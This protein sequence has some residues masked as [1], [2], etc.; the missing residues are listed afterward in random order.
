[1]KFK[2]G[3]LWYIEI[4]LWIFDKF[5]LLNEFNIK[6]LCMFGAWMNVLASSIYSYQS[7]KFTRLE[8]LR[9]KLEFE[10]V[11]NA[12][13]TW[14]KFRSNYMSTSNLQS[15]KLI[16]VVM[17]IMIRILH[18]KCHLVT[19]IF[20]KFTHYYQVCMSI[21]MPF[22]CANSFFLREKNSCKLCK[23]NICMLMDSQT[24]VHGPNVVMQFQITCLMYVDVTPT[25]TITFIVAASSLLYIDLLINLLPSSNT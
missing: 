11:S 25:T 7:S 17:R 21:V 22:K 18:W 16:D 13:W 9:R 12:Q 1:M 10:Y 23:H 14:L 6:I 19:F 15:T 5:W 3:V 4:M 2:E 24:K 20:R 8:K